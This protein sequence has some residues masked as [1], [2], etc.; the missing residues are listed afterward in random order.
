MEYVEKLLDNSVGKHAQWEDMNVECSKG[1]DDLEKLV[2]GSVETDAARVREHEGQSDQHA[3]LQERLGSIEQ[4]FGH[5]LEQHAVTKETRAQEHFAQNER[6]NILEQP[7]RHP[8][9]DSD[10]TARQEEVWHTR[11][12]EMEQRTECVETLLGD[13]ADK[14][15]CE[16]GL[17]P[18]R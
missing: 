1:V 18:S 17:M 3:T 7:R 8:V 11:N 16:S 14:L 4:L 15:R 6:I 10:A 12:A 5:Y 13:S 9:V 2:A